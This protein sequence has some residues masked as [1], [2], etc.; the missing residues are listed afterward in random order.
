MFGFTVLKSS[1]PKHREILKKM[2]PN[3]QFVQLGDYIAINHMIDKFKEDK[4]CYIDDNYLVMLDGVVFNKNYLKNFYHC[5]WIRTIIKMYEDKGNTFFDYFRGSF[6]GV[7]YDKYK[8]TLILFS[9]HIGSKFIYY[10]NQDD[11]SIMSSFIPNIYEFLKKTNTYYSLSVENA[12]VLLTYGYM[13]ENRTLCSEIFKLRPGCY[14][15]IINDKLSERYYCRLN[16]EPV[17]ISDSDAIEMIDEHFRSSLKLEFEKDIEYGYSQHLVALSGGLDSRM[18]S[19]VA[20][21]MG[22]INQLNYTFSQSNYLDETTPKKIAED[23]GHEWIFK[24]LDSGLWLLDFDYIVSQTGGNVLYFGSAHGNSLMKNL[25][26]GDMGMFHTGLLGDV[27]IGRSYCGKTDNEQYKRLDGSFGGTLADKVRDVKFKETFENREIGVLYNRGFSGIQ[28]ATQVGYSLNESFAPFEN[29]DLIKACLQLPYH[30]TREYYYK[31]WIISKYPK[32]AD[33]VWT[34]LKG[35]KI[36]DRTININ[37]RD[38]P[39]SQI[40]PRAKRFVLRRIVPNHMHV[41]KEGMNPIGYYLHSN[42]V[43][44]KKINNY[45]SENIGLIQDTTLLS[46]LQKLCNGV[47]GIEK[48]QAITLIE[49]VRQFFTK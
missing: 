22:Y 6:S 46:D 36:T 20:H 47:N 29:I 34:G 1:N 42:M 48:V 9:D 28:N 44:Q 30:K 2:F 41:K 45:I 18:T 24:A 43:L 31:K 5:D 40:I 23:Y 4:I 8:D 32:A 7:L 26:I 10:L 37:G 38:V 25:Y 13:L 17:N 12:Y 3:C 33:Y 39:L 27:T 11:F 49:A 16:N 15:T 14:I 19:L 21:D 35:A